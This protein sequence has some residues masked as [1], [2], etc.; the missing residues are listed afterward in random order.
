MVL[1]LAD[2]LLTEHGLFLL[3]GVVLLYLGAEVLVKGAAGLA[4]G[5][6]LHAALVGVT[7]VAFA[8]TAPELFIGV[9]SGIEGDAQLGLGAIL[10]SNIANIGLVLGVSALIRPLSV[11]REVV[12]KHVPFMAL[13]AVLV[14]LFGLD[15]TIGRVEGGVFLLVLAAFTV[16][17]YRGAV[18]E[19]AGVDESGAVADGGAVV[20]EMPD[21][22]PGGLSFRHVAY[23]VVGLA[24]LFFGSRW[25]IDS[26]RSMLYQF[27]FTQRLIGL[28]VLAFGTSLP[29]FAASVVA[30]VRGEADF[31]VGNVVGSNIYNVLAVLGLLAVIVPVFV[32]SGV[33]SFDFPALIAFTVAAVV[34]MLRG[35]EVG[36]LDG[37]VLLGGYLVF[38]YLLIP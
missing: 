34:V 28:T 36:R 16:V 22:D 1:Q 35:G 3:L 23:L 15:G 4:L 21:V 27:G 33:S 12:R 32:S 18:A 24:L 14:V 8:T 20:E 2:V 30:A 37:A 17:L 29:E 6:G 38:F 31:S 26:G 25:L 19:D 7:V 10:G 5:V 11:S 9:I 13:A